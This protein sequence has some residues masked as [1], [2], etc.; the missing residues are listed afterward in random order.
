[1][2]THR[3]QTST[4]DGSKRVVKL[5]EDEFGRY[6]LRKFCDFR[7]TMHKVLDVDNEFDAILKY[8]KEMN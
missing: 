8:V 6:H 4:W 1:M 2:L 7:E 3:K 5:Q